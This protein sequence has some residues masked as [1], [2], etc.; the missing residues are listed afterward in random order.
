MLATIP[1]GTCK[2]K[3][4]CDDFGVMA[5]VVTSAKVS[6]TWSTTL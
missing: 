2:T 3:E 4:R 1:K 6:M 5:S